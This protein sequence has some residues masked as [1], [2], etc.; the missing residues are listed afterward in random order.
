MANGARDPSSVL[1]RLKRGLFM[2][3]TELLAKV[4]G[5]IRA[6]FEPD[7]AALDALEE[8]LLAADVAPQTAEDLVAA[9]AK[10][11]V[12][13]AAADTFRAAAVEQLEVWAFRLDVPLVKHKAGADPAAVVHDACAIALA[14]KADL[15]LVDTAGRL[16][17]KH[18]L[19]EELSK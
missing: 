18:N 16:H 8:R 12:A 13:L 11:S 9:A 7:P 15:L 4:G 6:T 10:K 14:R 5:A 1:A 17:T 19:M 3:H 2:T